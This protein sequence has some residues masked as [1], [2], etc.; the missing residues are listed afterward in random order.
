MDQDQFEKFTTGCYDGQ[1]RIKITLVTPSQERVV[2]IINGVPNSS[3]I[4]LAN[5][6]TMF[7]IYCLFV[8][9]N[10]GEKER[11]HRPPLRVSNFFTSTDCY[12]EIYG[13][14]EWYAWHKL[15]VSLSLSLVLYFI[16]LPLLPL[17]L[18][19]LN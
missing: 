18:F 19:S 10:S 5:Q 17:F 1:Q 11:S 8:I 13:E 7:I 2:K 15:F 16:S 14:L 12:W 9:Q 6:R 4:N 3:L